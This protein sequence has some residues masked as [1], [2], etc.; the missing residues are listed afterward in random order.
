MSEAKQPV[1]IDQGTSE[2]IS[3]SIETFDLNAPLTAHEIEMMGQVI[4]N[5]RGRSEK[6]VTVKKH[7]KEIEDDEFEQNTAPADSEL[8]YNAKYAYYLK[9]QNVVTLIDFSDGWES[10]QELVLKPFVK[11]QRK[12]NKEYRGVDPNKAFTLRIREQT[13]EDLL[14]FIDAMIG[15]LKEVPKPVLNQK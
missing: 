5:N 7:V 8:D 6:S 11:E 15:S 13:A 14:K 9:C 4:E 3:S 1:V 12:A 10:F 2:A